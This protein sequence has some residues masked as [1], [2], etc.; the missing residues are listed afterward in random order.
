MSVWRSLCS[1]HF[2]YIPYSPTFPTPLL[3][4]ARYILKSVSD[5]YIEKKMKSLV[6]NLQRLS[7]A[8]LAVIKGKV[9]LSISFI[10]IASSRSKAA[11]VERWFSSNRC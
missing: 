2:P 9:H 5:I 11:L 8:L 4:L 7:L 10:K 6:A 3:R 1:P